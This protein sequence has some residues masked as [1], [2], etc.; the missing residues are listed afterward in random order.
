MPS[1]PEAGFVKSMA[2]VCPDIVCRNPTSTRAVTDSGRQIHRPEKLRSESTENRKARVSFLLWG[3]R[4]HCFFFFR[5]LV[6]FGPGEKLN[7]FILASFQMCRWR[8][9][10]L[11]GFRLHRKAKSK[12]QRTRLSSFSICANCFPVRVVSK[13]HWLQ[14]VTKVANNEANALHNGSL[15]QNCSNHEQEQKY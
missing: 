4:A 15:N 12:L 7:C 8:H 14:W 9:C 11:G 10:F 3:A 13:F 1:R 6:F 5:D 2:G